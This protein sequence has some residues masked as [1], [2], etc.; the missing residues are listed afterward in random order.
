VSDRSLC[1]ET[2]GPMLCARYLALRVGKQVTGPGS[3]HVARMRV[4][5]A[6]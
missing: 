3:S 1:C 4:W 6:I 5:E 2:A